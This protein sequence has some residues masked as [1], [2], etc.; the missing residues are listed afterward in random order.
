MSR[1]AAL[2]TVSVRGG[3]GEA[4]SLG[5][6]DGAGTSLAAVLVA[7]LGDLAATSGDGAEM[8]R[9]LSA[10]LDGEQ[11][12]VILEH[13]RSGTAADIVDSAGAVRLRLRPGDVP[14]VRCGCL[15][16]LPPAATSGRLAVQVNDGHGTKELFVGELSRRF[17]AQFP[18]LTLQIERLA[19]G[20]VLRDA[21]ERDGI[22]KV[23]LARIDEP[24]TGR[25]DATGKWVGAAD[26]A[27]VEL[28]V[29]VG[30]QKARL[31]PDLVHRYLTGEEAA[32]AEIVQFGGLQFDEAQVEVTLP[33]ATRRLV[34]IAHPDTAR[35]VTRALPD[36]D[37]DADGEPTGPSL[38]AGLRAVLSAAGS[39]TALG[40][41]HMLDV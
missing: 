17:R 14:L 27:R 10:E 29:S 5:S 2:Y 36:L 16:D 3:Q 7:S 4:P 26:A 12:F 40:G 37:V 38:L 9:A 35:P 13:G 19:E 31:V 11:V 23:T 22:E 20:D 28:S 25:P 34:D 30:G 15:F 39:R 21:V 24:G 18:E 32:F 6:I 33:D 8:L 1:R 41:V